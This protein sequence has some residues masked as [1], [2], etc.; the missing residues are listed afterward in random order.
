M[1]AAKTQ[2]SKHVVIGDGWTALASVGFLIQNQTPVVWIANTGA[3]M[4]SALPTLDN[5]PG[6]ELWQRLARGFGIETG[7]PVSGSFL[8]EFRNKAFR[9]PSWIKAPTPETRVEVQKESLWAPELR[10]AP[11]WEARFPESLTEIESKIRMLLTGDSEEGAPWR[12]LIRRIEEIP[13]GSFKIEGD[14]IKSVVLGSGEEIACETVLY[15]DRWDALPRIQG[16]PKNLPF[17]R[18]REPA[19]ALQAQFG[20]DQAIG[21]GVMEGFYSTLHKESGE[22]F[23]RHLWGH[24]STDGMKSYWTVC[25]TGD[26]VEDNHQIAKK[27]RRL[28]TGLD[29]MFTGSSWLPEGKAEFMTNVVGEAVRFHESVVFAEGERSDDPVLHSAAQGIQFMTDGY[30]P[31]SALIQV[32]R[33]LGLPEATVD[34]SE[35]TETFSE[36]PDS[37][38]KDVDLDGPS[39]S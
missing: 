2:A 15:A 4:F 29:K 19:S 36:G 9:E 20:H 12:A 39:A 30:G 37:E 33:A 31:A 24:F 38:A 10:L 18:R 25:L 23:E 8:R 13:V 22:E 3:R 32:A 14:R 6:V 5:G 16:L 28:K 21:A 17:I 11:L 26:E 7:A 34:V 35:A 27:L 1:S